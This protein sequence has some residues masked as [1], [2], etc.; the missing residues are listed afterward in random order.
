MHCWLPGQ[1]FILGRNMFG[2]VR[3]EWLDDSWKGW[4]GDNPPYHAP[5][6]VLARNAR[7]PIVME[8][9]RRSTSLRARST[10]RSSAHATPRETVTSRSEV[11][12]QPFVSTRGPAWS[13][14]RT[15]RFRL[16]CSDAHRTNERSF[17]GFVRLAWGSALVHT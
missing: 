8:G 7:E 9:A 17:R 3:G 4:W 6:F 13:M 5:K 1:A 11:V 14:N 2:P 12:S 15:S 16:S 10:P